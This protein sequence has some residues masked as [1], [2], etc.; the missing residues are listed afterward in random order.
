MRSAVLAFRSD[1]FLMRSEA[2]MH[3]ESDALAVL[4]VYQ[5]F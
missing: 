1:P 3:Y 2:A 4:E 5:G